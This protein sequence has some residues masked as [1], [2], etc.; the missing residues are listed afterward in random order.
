MFHPAEQSK[1][2]LFFRLT[3]EG[4]GGGAECVH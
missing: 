1:I 3:R 2:V 4:G